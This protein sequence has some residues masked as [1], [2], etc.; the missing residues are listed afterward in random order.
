[1]SLR[2]RG[3]R[4]E[5]IQGPGGWRPRIVEGAEFGASDILQGLSYTSI[6]GTSGTDSAIWLELTTE[7]GRSEPG[8]TGVKT[9]LFQVQNQGNA[10]QDALG[11][12][13]VR[14]PLQ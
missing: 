1:M 14:L 10:D 13:G 3:R 11:H 2:V 6:P 4:S 12:C 5:R 8:R 7:R 9:F